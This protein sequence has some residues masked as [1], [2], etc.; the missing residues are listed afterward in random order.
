MQPLFDDQQLRRFQEL[1]GQAPWLYSG[2]QMFYPPV[3]PPLPLA[4]PLFLEQE[5]R[6]LQGISN[7]GDQSQF[8]YPY[9]VPQGVQENVELKKGPELVLEENRKLKERLEALEDSRCEED[10]KFST[11]DGDTKEAV[12]PPEGRKSSL[13]ALEAET[14]KEAVRP[15][16]EG[17]KS[18]QARPEP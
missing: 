2:G 6:R 8:A 9:M 1:H 14:T 15:P 13:G 16:V 7:V 10:Q 18:S 17:R 3:M 5:E 11:P 12:R 4:R